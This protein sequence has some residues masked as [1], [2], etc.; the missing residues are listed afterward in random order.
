MQMEATGPIQGM[1]G[2]LDA[3]DNLG[4]PLII[5]SIQFSPGQGQPGMVKVNLDMGIVDFTR[6]KEQQRRNN[7]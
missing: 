5:N 3:L 6:W 1:L 7:A 4:Y 2:F